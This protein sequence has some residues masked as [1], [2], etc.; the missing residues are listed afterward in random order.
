MY[1]PFESLAPTS[2]IWIYQSD[3]KFSER[4]K[5]IIEQHLKL[6]TERWSAHGQALRTSF[7][8]RFDYF[9]V[10]AADQDHYAPSGCS[11]DDSVRTIQ[12]I[13]QELGT[14][15]FDRQKIAFKKDDGIQLVPLNLLKAKYEQGLWHERT[16]VFNNLVDTKAKLDDKWIITAGET[17]LKRYIPASSMVS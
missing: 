4:E 13:G 11:I 8:I 6:F 5:A 7:D 10:L 2:R 17:W 16:L 15:L 3:K 14:D 9:I 12:E 1:V